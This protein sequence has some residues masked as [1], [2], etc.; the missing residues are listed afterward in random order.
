MTYDFRG[1][2][3]KY[4][5]HQT[6]LYPPKASASMIPS[7]D[8]DKV[9]TET[10][11]VVDYF[12]KQGMP[13]T[14]ICIGAAFYGR[15]WAGVKNTNNGLYQTFTSV[16]KGTWDD[17]TSG[18]TG[19]FEYKDV[20]AKVASGQLTRYWDGEVKAPYAFSASS[21]LMISYEDSQ[22]IGEKI[23]Y[24]KSKN[25]AGIMIWDLS[26]DDKGEL[27]GVIYSQLVTDTSGPT[28]TGS[29]GGGTNN[30]SGNQNG[31]ASASANSNAM[32]LPVMMVLVALGSFAA[33]GLVG[34][35]AYKW[36]QRK[37]S[38]AQAAKKSSWLP[39]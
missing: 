13:S 37:T 19:V 10:Q 20:K 35:G 15:G 21:G 8:P 33:A 7:D 16:P 28:D 34:F 1:G 32:S 22:S 31:G 2:W 36:S 14:K 18:N 12:L 4:T 30:G 24:L 17:G 27:S 25:L 29:G 23:K 38:K 11:S 6:P 9:L 3:S 39:F 26:S 5:G